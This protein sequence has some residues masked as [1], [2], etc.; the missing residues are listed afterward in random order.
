MTSS[1]TTRLYLGL[2][3]CIA[4]IL[5]Y[6]FV[7]NQI[8]VLHVVALTGNVGGALE[9]QVSMTPRCPSHIS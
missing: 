5:F 8:N 9:Y 6:T 3:V 4:V 7:L 2:R 1:K